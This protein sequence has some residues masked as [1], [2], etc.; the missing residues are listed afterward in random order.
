MEEG[1]Q[2]EEEV[3][4]YCLVTGTKGSYKQ[5]RQSGEEEAYTHRSATG[6]PTKGGDSMEGIADENTG[7][8]CVNT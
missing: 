3:F 2:G 8:V 1:Q 6:T 7:T 5:E 4:T